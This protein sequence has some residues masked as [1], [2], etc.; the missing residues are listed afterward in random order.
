MA[1]SRWDS[2][3][4]LPVSRVGNG[5][6]RA[7]DRT[8]TKTYPT[9]TELLITADAGVSNDVGPAPGRSSCNTSRTAAAYHQRVALSARDVEVEQRAPA[10][11]HITQNW[12]GRP[13]VDHETV[14]Q[15]IGSVRTRTGLTVKARLDRRPYPAGVKVPDADMDRLRLTPAAFHGD[16]NYTIHPRESGE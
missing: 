7:W 4:L 1:A 8:G 11:C 10:F 6:T 15:L 5:P 14:V 13:L 9:A 12:R 2:Q 16:W 3:L